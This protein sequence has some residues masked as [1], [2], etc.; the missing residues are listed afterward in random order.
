[1][2]SFIN[3]LPHPVTFPEK[4]WMKETSSAR[5]GDTWST[6]H[7]AV[8]VSAGHGNTAVQPKGGSPP[9]ALG[10]TRFPP[11]AGCHPWHA[12]YLP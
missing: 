1:M 10:W 6:D 7:A 5:L 12:S 2:H 11:P 3:P 9:K 8:I 4:A